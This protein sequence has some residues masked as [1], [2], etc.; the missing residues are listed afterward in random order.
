VPWHD[1]LAPHRKIPSTI[2]LPHS[3]HHTAEGIGLI[4]PGRRTLPHSSV[5][6]P[7]SI[8]P[9]SSHIPVGSDESWRLTERPSC[10]E[11]RRRLGKPNTPKH[12]VE[13][14][15]VFPASHSF[16]RRQTHH[17]RGRPSDLVASGTTH[18]GTRPSLSC[19]HLSHVSGSRRVLLAVSATPDLLFAVVPFWEAR[20]R[21]CLCF[22]TPP[23]TNQTSQQQQYPPF[24]SP[25]LPRALDRALLSCETKSIF[26]GASPS[27]P[28]PGWSKSFTPFR[29]S[30]RSLRIFSIDQFLARAR[31]HT[32]RPSWN[33]VPTQSPSWTQTSS[34]SL[35]SRMTPMATHQSWYVCSDP[36]PLCAVAFFLFLFS[37]RALTLTILLLLRVGAWR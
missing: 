1:H 34:R 9:A 24:S 25:P 13:F 23:P 21:V 2:R 7:S 12:A 31:G 29:M 35:T 17:S 15:G 32:T 18:P 30:P 20:S 3:P 10:D 14:S 16:V 28:F 11:T 26:F 36:A 22:F 4:G 8:D 37:S 33:A 19:L 6:H 5:S 27:A